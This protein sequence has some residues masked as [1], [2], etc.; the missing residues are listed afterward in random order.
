MQRYYIIADGVIIGAA[1]TREDAVDFIR[2]KQ[3]RE[4]HPI[5]KAEFSILKGE[6][7]F[8]HYT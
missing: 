5:L 4:T 6:E 8:I 2:V 7:E 3:K 1:T